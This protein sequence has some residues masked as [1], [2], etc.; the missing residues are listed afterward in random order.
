MSAQEH[1]DI[2]ERISL[3][4]LFKF[5]GYEENQNACLME[6]IDE[7]IGPRSHLNLTT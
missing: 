2:D 7:R 1:L 3:A 4:R 5:T 6:N